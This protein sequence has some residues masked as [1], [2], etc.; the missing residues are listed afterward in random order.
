MTFD[1]KF[2]VFKTPLQKCLCGTD[3]CKGYL[4]LMDDKA[5]KEQLLCEFC[6]TSVDRLDY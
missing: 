3:K 2:D 5:E 6:G 1:Y 4:G